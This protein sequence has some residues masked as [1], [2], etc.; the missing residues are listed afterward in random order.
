MAGVYIN[1]ADSLQRRAS[2]KGYCIGWKSR[3]GFERGHQDEEMSYGDA[4]K[5]AEELG[6]KDHDK[7]YWPE[8]I[9]DAKFQM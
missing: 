3:Y 1:R 6:S 2:D 4:V 5:K 8:M 7:V 9:M